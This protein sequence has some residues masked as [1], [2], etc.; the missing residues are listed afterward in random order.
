MTRVATRE[1][2]NTSNEER[3]PFF[4]A[5]F[6]AAGIEPHH[7]ANLRSA[8]TPT[9]K[10]FRSAKDGMRIAK[11]NELAGELKKLILLFILRPVEPTDLVV[12]A[13]SVV[14]AVLRSS[15][16]V[17]ASEHWHALR[18]KECGQKIPALS[19]ANRVD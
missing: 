16:L 4:V 8:D 6:A 11:S 9:L 13:I 1:L 15:P 3:R 2:P 7:V 17:S 12:L 19:L 18:K 10:E 14:I 5:H